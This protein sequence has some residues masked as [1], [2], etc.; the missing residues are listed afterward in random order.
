MLKMLSLSHGL[1]ILDFYGTNSLFYIDTIIAVCPLY[2]VQFL[3]FEISFL[4]GF[5][6]LVRKVGED[7]KCFSYVRGAFSKPLTKATVYYVDF[8]LN[9]IFC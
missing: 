9:V 8:S 2:C 4:D 3:C 7:L 5:T 1:N 6:V